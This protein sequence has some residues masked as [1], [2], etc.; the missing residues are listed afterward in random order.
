MSEAPRRRRTVPAEPKELPPVPAAAPAEQAAPVRRRRETGEQAGPETPPPVMRRPQEAR[1]STERLEETRRDPGTPRW[2]II[3]TAALFFLA[4]SL[5]TTDALLRAWLKTNED[6]KIAAHQAVVDAHP[7]SYRDWI[8]QYAGEN[9]LEPA[10]VASIILNESSFRSGAESSVGARGLMQL[11][12]ETA[13]WIAGKLK[14]SDYSFDR[15][16]DPETNI[17]YGCWYLGYLSDLFRGDPVCVAA[18]YHAGQ[19]QVTTWLSDSTLSPDGVTLNLEAMT[20]GPTKNYAKKVTQAYGIY[21]VLYFEADVSSADPD[22][23][24]V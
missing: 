20:D 1:R 13:E 9:N 23:G 24:S 18:A 6:A 3:L 7:L 2:L 17:R 15:M 22:A 19:G 11:M 4:L 5:F 16:Y 10:F 14:D 12:P 8:G 21:Q